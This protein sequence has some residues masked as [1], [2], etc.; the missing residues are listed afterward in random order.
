VTPQQYKR[1][2]DLF[3]AALQQ[4]P[5]RRLEFINERFAD[6]ADVRRALLAMLTHHESSDSRLDQ[7]IFDGALGVAALNDAGS[8]MVSSMPKRIGPY[9]LVG[10]LG[11]GG[12][13]VI[14]RALQEFPRREVALKVLR[15]MLMSP[16]MRRR[17]HGEIQALARL[18]HPNIASIYDAGTYQDGDQERPY[19]TMELVDGLP[20]AQYASQHELTVRQRVAIMIDVCNAVQ[21]AHLRGVIHRDLKPGNILVTSDGRAKVLDFGIARATEVDLVQTAVQSESGGLLGTLP[22]MSPEQLESESSAVDLRSDVYSLGVVT[23]ELLSGS[24]PFDLTSLTLTEAVRTLTHEE[25]TR[26]GAVAPAC[27]GE[28][29]VIVAT[30]ME[31]DRTRRYQSAQAL[32]DDLQAHLEHRPIRSRPPGPLLR[33]RKWVRRRPTAATAIALSLLAAMGIVAIVVAQQ[34]QR[35]QA[36]ARE[37]VRVIGE[38]NDAVELYTT[39]FRE[40][41]NLERELADVR[42]ALY[43]F[44]EPEV[45]AKLAQQEQALIHSQREHEGLF[46]RTLELISTARRHGAEESLVRAMLARLYLARLREAEAVGDRSNRSVYLNLVKRH[47][48]EGQFAVELVQRFP[49]SI[50][51]NPPGAQVHL[52]RMVEQS[53]LF[54]DGEPRMVPVPIHGQSDESARPGTISLRVV[55]G[56]GALDAE[57]VILTVAGEPIEHCVLVL[58]AAPPLEQYDRLMTING[59]A[60]HGMYDVHRALSAPADSGDA[61]NSTW[62]FRRGTDQFELHRSE[63]IERGIVLADPAHIVRE[64][65]GPA[66]V[67]HQGAL[68]AMTLPPGIETRITG[69]PL[70]RSHGSLVA[71]TPVSDLDLESGDYIALLWLDGYEPLRFPF[72]VSPQSLHKI[73]G[74]LHLRLTPRGATPPGFVR[75]PSGL[76]AHHPG[77]WIMDREVTLEEY[78]QFLNDPATQATIGESAELALV[79]RTGGAPQLARDA[80][81]YYLVPDTWRHDWPIFFVSWHDAMAYAAWRTAQ[82]RQQGRDVHFAIPRH[83]EWLD[84]WGCSGDRQHPWGT[85]FRPYW[86]SSNYARKIP[87]PEPVLSFPIDESNFGVFDLAGNVSEWIDAWWVE[88]RDQREFAGSSWG[89]GGFTALP[90]FTQYGQNGTFSRTTVGTIGIRLVMREGP[91]PTQLQRATP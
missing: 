80:Q 87:A 21:H 42:N 29:E 47:D 19:F 32:A 58:E 5:E 22:Y 4:V 15:G 75:L 83:T 28:L 34:I 25:P 81:G 12:M 65:G 71:T 8:A 85:A 7:P 72:S 64:L 41:R 84:A 73:E 79:P 36:D 63:L 38:A 51:T 20:L 46:Y 76:S 23:F 40:N 55:D 62:L 50:V 89:Q 86:T 53:E 61:E 35:R 74:G 11:S 33:V 44:N 43:R 6:D 57:D 16:A 54:A 31:R 27:R 78:L 90:Q 37:Q 67:W 45:A 13:S 52:F 18:S 1:M 91:P 39:Q 77:V 66:T 56:G 82:A 69:K 3:D 30:A 59:A 88:E 17:F 24:L 10:V 68:Q 70:F 60:V 9:E 2:S 49:V 48:P 14:Y 26:L